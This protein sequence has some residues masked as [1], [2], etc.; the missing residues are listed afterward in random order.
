MPYEEFEKHKR[1]VLNDLK[2]EKEH[3]EDQQSDFKHLFDFSRDI[4]TPLP[5]PNNKSR[6]EDDAIEI[7]DVSALDNGMED[8]KELKR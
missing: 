2:R 4:E 8:V 1:D 6:E 5:E 3:I 7:A